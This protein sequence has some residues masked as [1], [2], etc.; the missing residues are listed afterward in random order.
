MCAP[1]TLPAPPSSATLASPGPHLAL[2]RMPSPLG[3]AVR[4]SVQPAAEL[5]YLQRHHDVLHV[6][7]ALRAHLPPI[8]VFEP[9]PCAL[10]LRGCHPT[11]S[12]SQLAPRPASYALLFLGSA[13]RVGVQP[14]ADSRHVQRHRHELHVQRALCPCPANHPAPV[15]H[16]DPHRMLSVL[17]S[18]GRVGVQPAAGF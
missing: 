1:S 10:P 14:T 6:Q 9:S 17:L 16:V 4:K 8:C 2:H 5:Q 18:A 11:P 7:G 12:V 13:V 15:P 3:S